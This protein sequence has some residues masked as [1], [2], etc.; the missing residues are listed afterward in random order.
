MEV[1]NVP[2]SRMPPGM[3]SVVESGLSDSHEHLCSEPM[4]GSERPHAFVAKERQQTS[5]ASQPT[6]VARVLQEEVSESP[7]S[8]PALVVCSVVGP[9]PAGRE[10]RRSVLAAFKE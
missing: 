10:T 9:R 3:H 7:T 4:S 6:I 1:F 5:K 2:R 8:S